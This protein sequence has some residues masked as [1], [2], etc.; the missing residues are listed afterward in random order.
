MSFTPL[1][2]RLRP[3]PAR[4]GAILSVLDIGT[5]KIA[6]LIARLAPM[7]ASEVLRGRTHRCRILGIGH[8]R[9]R[10]I[11][12]GAIVDMEEAEQAIRLAVDAAERMAGVLVESVILTVTG[13]RLGSQHFAAKIGVGN[14]SVGERDVQKVLAAATATAERN[15]RA[16]LHSLP[17]GYS[18]DGVRG[19]RDPKGMMGEDLGVDLHLVGCEASTARNLML[20]VERCHL[21]VEALVATPYAAGLSALVDDEADMGVALVDMGGGTTS[22]GVFSDGRLVHADAVAVGGHH[23]TMDIARGL[24]SR[25]SDAERLKTLYG[26]CIPSP[27]DERETIAVIQAGEDGDH[28]NHVPKSQLTRIIRPRVEEILELVRDRLKAAGYGAKASRRLVMTGGASQLTGLPELARSILSPQVR[29]GRPLGIQGLPESAKSP[30][31]AAAVG[32]LVY[33]QVAG[34]EHFEPGQHGSS[35]A[36]GSDGYIAKVGRWLKDSF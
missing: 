23:V 17:V 22:V 14:K 32:L 35:R 10:G 16:V 15:G 19:I 4:K 25:L 21:G 9:S 24:T 31:F 3:L 29:I 30:A 11:K 36:P 18:L 13:G 20:A 27:S 34:V 28:P 5:S 12:A 8:Q 1:I 6:C 26:S 2:P 33:P 7:E